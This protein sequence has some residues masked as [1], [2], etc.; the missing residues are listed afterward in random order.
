MNKVIDQYIFQNKVNNQDSALKPVKYGSV[1]LDIKFEIHKIADFRQ[2]LTLIAENSMQLTVP[3]HVEGKNNQ[4][5]TDI[6]FD[7]LL[8]LQL[9]IVYVKSEDG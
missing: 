2:Y 6:K 1:F 3:I 8:G 5:V 7:T 4:G 9:N